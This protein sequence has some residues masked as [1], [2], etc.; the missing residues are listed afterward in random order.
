M[1]KNNIDVPKIKRALV[2]KSVAE[3]TSVIGGGIALI[4]LEYMSWGAFCIISALLGIF[5][6]T[7]ILIKGKPPKF[8]QI[9][10][11]AKSILETALLAVG[12]LVLIHSGQMAGGIACVGGCLIKI[13]S[14]ALLM[15]W[16][17]R[18]YLN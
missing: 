4:A 3:N 1:K 15:P 2:I 9:I 7:H 12:G 5:L 6:N 8:G 10:S 17:E 16:I 13:G 18:K 14:D 11:I